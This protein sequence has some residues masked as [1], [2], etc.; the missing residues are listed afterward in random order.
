MITDKEI[1]KKKFCRSICTYDMHAVAQQKIADKLTDIIRN[2]YENDPRRVLEI[3]CGTGKLTREIITEYKN[4][5]Y[6]LNDIN[7]EITGVIPSIMNNTPYSLLIGDAEKIDYPVNIDLIVSASVFQWF[8]NLPAFLL[9]MKNI[10]TTDGYMFFS[11][12]GEFNL[13][14]IRTINGTGL[15]YHRMNDLE[16]MLQKDF[17]ILYMYEE[18][19]TLHFPSPVDV[20]KHLR[21][22]GVNGGF[23]DVW[24]KNKLHLFSEAYNAVFMSEKGVTLTYHPIYIGVK[25]NTKEFEF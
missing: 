25:L 12:F 7:T 22:T 18:L 2:F 20:L 6:Y 10:L 3:G 21:A 4:A 5:Y 16:I 24:S 23:S 1:V 13:K 14:E 17:S 15:D 11:T 19:I 9:K 8:A